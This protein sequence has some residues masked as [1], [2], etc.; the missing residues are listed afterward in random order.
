MNYTLIFILY[1]LGGVMFELFMSWIITVL[2][3]TNEEDLSHLRF[4]NTEKIVNLIIWPYHF[5]VFFV[6]LLFGN[7]D[8][9][10]EEE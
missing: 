5:V 8:E 1:T 6:G 2:E 7:E 9:L 3:R 4:S 10:D